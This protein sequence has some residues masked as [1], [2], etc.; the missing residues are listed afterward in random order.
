MSD[1]SAEVTRDPL[2][3]PLSAE[4]DRGFLGEYRAVTVDE[5][6]DDWADVRRADRTL[7]FATIR[8][9]PRRGEGC[10]REAGSGT[11]HLGVGR[12]S[13]HGG[14]TEDGL[15]EGAWIVAHAFARA[16]DVTPWEGLLTAVRLAAGKLAFC[17]QKIGTATEDRQL[18][19]PDNKGVSEAA[20]TQD[21]Q[22]TNLFFW[23]KQAEM[24]HDK[25]AKVSALAIQQ[26]VA[27]RMVRQLELEAQLM[28]KAT[29]ITL[30][31]LGIHDDDQ[32]SRALGIMSRTLLALE[33]E[34]AG[35]QVKEMS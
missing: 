9:G 27:E 20:R 5:D 17:E 7:C 35:V 34:E 23:V 16:L 21:F 2:R 10:T 13:L 25:L 32:R 29:Q 31:E 4:W 11:P 33:A 19:P 14:K 1:P 12:C 15:R 22:G 18:E 3:D 8:S 28:L 24:W 26:G 6:S 30:D